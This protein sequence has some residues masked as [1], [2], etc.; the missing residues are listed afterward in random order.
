MHD[1]D[2]Q[3]INQHPDFVRVMEY[4]ALREAGKQATKVEI[5]EH[6]GISRPTLDRWIL[7]WTN[8]G[9]LARCRERFLTPTI[10]EEMRVA[11]LDAM[12]DWPEILKRQRKIAIHSRSDRNANEAAA[13]IWE[14]LVRPAL[15]AEVEAGVDELDY[16]KLLESGNISINPHDI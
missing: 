5:A 12:A 4:I 3:E 10:L 8:S 6:F 13:N 9:L 14:W 7:K 15:E 1:I 2:I 16:A 11:N